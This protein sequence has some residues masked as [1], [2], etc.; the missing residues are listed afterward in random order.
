MVM[1]I[2]VPDAANPGALAERLSVVFGTERVALGGDRG[3]VAIRVARESDP[4]VL[5]VLDAVERWLDQAAVASAEMWLGK[6]SYRIARRPP[7]ATWQ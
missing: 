3:E 5:R 4:A 7:A 2:V 1:R 6:H